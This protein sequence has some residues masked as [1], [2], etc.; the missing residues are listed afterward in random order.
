MAEMTEEILDLH[1]L[2]ADSAYHNWLELNGVLHA[3]EV[4]RAFMAAWNILSRFIA[5]PEQPEVDWFVVHE[6]V[7]DTADED[8]VG[9]EKALEAS[10]KKHGLL[11]LHVTDAERRRAALDTARTAGREG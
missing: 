1:H 2:D 8:G 3:P 4:E 11:V 5:G 10:F 7:M 9:G 6:A